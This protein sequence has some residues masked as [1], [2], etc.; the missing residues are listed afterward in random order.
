[1][2]FARVV[3]VGVGLMGRRHARVVTQNS[4]ALVLAG[5]YDLDVH[6]AAAASRAWG[7]PAFRSEEEAIDNADLVLIASPIATHAR[8]AMS[9]LA[10]GRHV[11]V[12]KPIC[13]SLAEAHAVLALAARAERHVFVGHSERFNPVVRA[14]ARLLRGD[15]V[16]SIELHRIGSGRAAAMRFI[17]GNPAPSDEPGVLVNLGVH[18][19][20]LASYLTG[21]AIDVRGAVGR[22]A[23]GRPGAA[24]DLAHVIL[25]ARRGAA[26]IGHVYVDRTSRTRHRTVRITTA[27]YVYEGDLLAHRLVRLPLRANA[28]AT[29]TDVPLPA[30]EPLVA[31]A[32]ALGEA[33]AGGAIR[34]IATGLDGARALAMAESAAER[35]RAARTSGFFQPVLPATAE[36]L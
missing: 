4:G 22:S 18:D 13:A 6:Q 8:I 2:S 36:K 14:L 11:F 7:V 17:D 3:I 25:A 29:P 20:D 34:E 33:L 10:A 12:E 27:R 1:M 35:I 28:N 24:E 26:A 30:E 31:Q 19:F 32:R 16:A 15:E 21:A 9:A 23:D 5:A